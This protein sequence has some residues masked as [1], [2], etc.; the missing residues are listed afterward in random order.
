[1][2]QAQSTHIFVWIMSEN[3]TFI[4]EKKYQK[5]TAYNKL[6]QTVQTITQS[7]QK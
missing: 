1:M 5:S 3:Y 2:D 7:V 6:T 4:R